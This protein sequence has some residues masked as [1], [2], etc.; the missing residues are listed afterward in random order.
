MELVTE[1]GPGAWPLGWLG[2]AWLAPGLA[3]LAGV[4]LACLACGWVGVWVGAGVVVLITLYEECCVFSRCAALA[5]LAW[6]LALGG[7]LA[8][9]GTP[10]ACQLS[11]GV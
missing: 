2:L 6:C 5:W 4:G 11:G 10:P 7:G 3:W 9:G 8:S 1:G